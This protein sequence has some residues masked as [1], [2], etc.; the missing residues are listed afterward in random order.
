[1]N[2]KPNNMMALLIVWAILLGLTF[3]IMPKFMSKKGPQEA[4]KP[5]DV[6]YQQADKAEKDAKADKKKLNEAI[7]KYQ[8]LIKAYPDTEYA[9]KALL[10]KGIILETEMKD[11]LHAVETYTSLRRDYIENYPEIAAEAQTHL[12]G[13]DKKN[14]TDIR[15]K[16]INYLVSMTGKNPKYSYFLALLIITLVFKFVTSPLSRWQFKGMKEMQKIQPLVKELQEQ[17]KGDKQLGEKLMALYKEHNVNPFGS[18]LPMLVQMPVMIVLYTMV[19]LYQVQFSNGEFLWIG[20][21]LA[22]A[23]PTIVAANLALPDIPMLVIYSISMFI[24]QKLTIVDP[25]QAEQQKMM[26][27]FMPIMFAVFFKGFP[28]AFMLYWLLFNVVST[29]QQ[30]FMLRPKVDDTNGPGNSAVTVE[31]VPEKPK[32]LPTNPG[33]A[34][35]RKR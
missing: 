16:I 22:H 4:V 6:M 3:L 23:Y 1:M 27:Y 7:N 19:R 13:I 10:R 14:S 5:A 30:Y 2:S 26:T 18:C 21:S 12:D 8:N 33:K 28:S 34:R 17:Y 32:S 11:T 9:P 24:S 29:T 31:P 35:R 15:Y 20:S 25:T